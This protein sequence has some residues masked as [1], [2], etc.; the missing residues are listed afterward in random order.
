MALRTNLKSRV[1]LDSAFQESTMRDYRF[2]GPDHVMSE[3][4]KSLHCY[5]SRGSLAKRQKLN[6]SGWGKSN[7]N[8]GYLSPQLHYILTGVFR[9]MLLDITNMHFLKMRGSF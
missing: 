9:I 5:Q 1:L 4:L 7:S 2:L 3:M 6:F 8:V